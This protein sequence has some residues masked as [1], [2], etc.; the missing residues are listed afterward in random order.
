M[1]YVDENMMPGERVLY[2]AHL[3]WVTWVPGA[4]AAA[5]FLLG[6]LMVVIAKGPLA[7]A[8][9]FVLVAAV[10]FIPNYIT[11]KTSEFAVTD[12]RVII[13]TGWLRQRSIE[14][15]LDKIEGIRVD[16]HF[17]DRQLG[18]STMVVEGTGGDKEAFRRIADPL[19]FRKQV[20]MAT[21]RRTA[22]PTEGR[23]AGR[24]ERD[25]PYCAERILAKAR[26]C[27]HCGREVAPVA[28]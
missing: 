19:E 12:Q 18:Y 26:V 11:F 9:V 23:L 8:G 5:L 17:T 6:A 2:R 14:T 15:L 13:K 7:A 21:A 27:K 1:S 10:C 3:H 20:Q 25:C 22:A 16:Q 24:D 28:I 4:V